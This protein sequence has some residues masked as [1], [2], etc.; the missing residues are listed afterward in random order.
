MI[1]STTPALSVLPSWVWLVVFIW[2]GM[3]IGSFVTMLVYRLPRGLP[4]WGRRDKKDIN[5]SA[6]RSACPHCGHVLGLRD[7]IPIVSYALGRGRCRY[8]HT[9]IGW[10]YVAIELGC[11]GVALIVFLFMV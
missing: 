7:L 4:L 10:H 6:N 1:S 3:I 9:P 2:F 8:C 11:V 5:R